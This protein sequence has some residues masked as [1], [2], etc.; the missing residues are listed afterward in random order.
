[1]GSGRVR[2]SRRRRGV[3]VGLWVGAGLVVVIG[4]GLWWDAT[5]IHPTPARVFNGYAPQV[6][7]VVF[8][9]LPHGELVEMIEGATNSPLSHCGIVALDRGRWV[10]VEAI[11]PVMETPLE[12]WIRR[13]RGWRLWAYR[14]EAA[15]QEGVGRFVEAARGFLGRPY[16]YRYRMDDEFLYC[17]ELVEKSYRIARWYIGKGKPASGRVY[18]ASIL[19]D[20]PDTSWAGK[21]KALMAEHTAEEAK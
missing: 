17:S 16:D 10:V 7:D 11:G 14:L 9:S 6:G 21:A 15:R 5:R 20:Y 18:L 1:M 19:K 8:Q 13:G 4:L 3:P 12:R 2:A